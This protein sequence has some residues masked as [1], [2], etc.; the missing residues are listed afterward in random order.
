MIVTLWGERRGFNPEQWPESRMEVEL[1]LQT[2]GEG[3]LPRSHRS[4]EAPHSSPLLP[5]PW[6]HSPVLGENPPQ[7]VVPSVPHAGSVCSLPWCLSMWAGMGSRAFEMRR[8]LPAH[9]RISAVRV[10]ALWLVIRRTREGVLSDLF[11][12]LPLPQSPPKREGR[13]G[14]WGWGREL[15]DRQRRI[16]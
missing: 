5:G 4:G 13:G 1:S 8:G 9:P 14:E 10:S 3:S 6:G 7:Q 2:G 15:R 11:P 12:L 16:Q